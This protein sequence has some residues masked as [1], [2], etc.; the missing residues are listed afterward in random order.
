MPILVVTSLI[1]Q[2]HFLQE[3]NL[4]D[5]IQVA[6]REKAKARPGLCPRVPPLN[7]DVVKRPI[8]HLERG[9]GVGKVTIRIALCGISKSWRERYP[10]E[11]HKSTHLLNMKQI[12]KP[13]INLFLA[14]HPMAEIDSGES[15]KDELKEDEPSDS[16][17]WAYGTQ[18]EGEADGYGG[19]IGM[20][21]SGDSVGGAVEAGGLVLGVRGGPQEHGAM[22]IPSEGSPEILASTLNVGHG[23][24]YIC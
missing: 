3:T 4:Y 24:E 23:G 15:I 1:N 6:E 13:D 12:S 17:L 21:V 8:P 14:Q 9:M 18:V 11:F 20:G 7:V 2:A 19:E 16:E 22:G 10:E 5:A